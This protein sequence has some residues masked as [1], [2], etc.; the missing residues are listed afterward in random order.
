[1][2]G[3]KL[4]NIQKNYGSR[5]VLDG[6]NLDFAAGSFVSIV[7]AS[8][9]GKSTL[10]RLIAG[11]ESASTG[12]VSYSKKLRTSFVF[13]DANLLDWRNVFENASLAFELD[14]DLQKKISETEI[15]SEVNASLHLVQLSAFADYFPHELSGGM[16]MRTSIA[17]ALASSP[18]LLL[19]DEPFAALDDNTRFE[20][21]IRLRA[22]AQEKKLN[23]IFVTHNISEAVF[24]SDR[25]VQIKEGRIGLDASIALV[26]IRDSNL[27]TSDNYYRELQKI[28]QE[29]L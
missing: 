13:Q 17:R 14:A 22:I 6:I 11:L 21:Q 26:K 23:V 25:I 4:S 9:S 12:E 15:A 1:M 2:T 8:G 18:Q 5:K 10:L 20:L 27:R 28:Y 29:L 24:L 7:G 3:F 16:K 19:L